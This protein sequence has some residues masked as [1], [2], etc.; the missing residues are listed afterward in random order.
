MYVCIYVI[1]IE[2]LASCMYA[3]ECVF[4]LFEW[5]VPK[6]RGD[7]RMGDT[8]VDAMRRESLRKSLKRKRDKKKSNHVNYC[9][10]GKIVTL[11]FDYPNCKRR[12]RNTR[13]L[14]SF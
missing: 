5:N 10:I 8:D 7:K 2:S 3:C 11:S 4:H 6:T 1:K 12:M 14:Q 13:M 9:L